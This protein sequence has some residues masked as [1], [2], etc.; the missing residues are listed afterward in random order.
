MEDEFERGGVFL[1]TYAAQLSVCA[2]RSSRKEQTGAWWHQQVQFCLIYSPNH[3]EDYRNTYCQIIYIFHPAQPRLAIQ[4]IVCSYIFLWGA[5]TSHNLYHSDL[6]RM[7][8][9]RITQSHPAITW[10]RHATHTWFQYRCQQR[11]RQREANKFLLRNHCTAKG[12]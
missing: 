10:S 2:E 5:L 1:A 4:C 8:R 9:T 7:E 6:F 3:Y 11:K 12:V